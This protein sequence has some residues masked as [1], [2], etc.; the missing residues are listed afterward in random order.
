M[1]RFIF[2]EDK[3]IVDIFL[4]L[5]DARGDERVNGLPLN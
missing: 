2:M 3:P 4:F 1:D 5:A